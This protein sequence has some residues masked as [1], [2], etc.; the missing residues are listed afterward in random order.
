[1]DGHARGAGCFRLFCAQVPWCSGL[2]Y[3][4]VK[5]EIAGSNPVGTA[6]SFPYASADSLLVPM[7][8][9]TGAPAGYQI[10][11]IDLATAD[12]AVM[13]Q[14]VALSKVLNTEMR[15]EDPPYPDAIIEA[16][17]RTTSKLAERTAFGAFADDHIVG[18]ATFVRNFTGSNDDIRELDLAVLPQHRRRGIGRSLLAAGLSGIA[19]ETPDS[20]SGSPRAALLRA[21]RY[22]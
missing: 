3:V 12:D 20:W 8:K 18:R 15:P 9:H 22:P 16:R 5:D 21:R 10:Q 7:D 11:P 1:M 13:G 14:L 2:A 4:P 6:S 17:L 19:D